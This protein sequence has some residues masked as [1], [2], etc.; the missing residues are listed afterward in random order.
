[1]NR[2]VHTGRSPFFFRSASRSQETGLLVLRPF[3]L[4]ISTLR[5]AIAL[6]FRLTLDG[7]AADL[8]LILDGEL[9]AH[10]LARHLE[11]DFAVLVF[12]VLDRG[13]L[14][15]AAGHGSGQLVAVQFELER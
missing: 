12:P 15:I 11:G 5:L 4:P 8:A 6:E 13:L 7:V 2:P 9:V 3:C 1:M 10:A 14:A